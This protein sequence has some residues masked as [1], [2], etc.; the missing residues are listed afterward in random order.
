MPDMKRDFRPAR[1][2]K[3]GSFSNWT[4]SKGS[5]KGGIRRLK[6]NKGEKKKRK[7]IQ[8]MQMRA[9]RKGTVQRAGHFPTPTETGS[10]TYKAAAPSRL[11]RSAAAAAAAAAAV[12]GGSLFQVK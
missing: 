5:R 6:T 9:E 10:S 2:E 12:V 11:G 3:E 1:P 8:D 7:T 4:S